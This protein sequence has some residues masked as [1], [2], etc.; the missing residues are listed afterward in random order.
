MFIVNVFL[1]ITEG[2]D[3]FCTRN[4]DMVVNWETKA[5]AFMELL[6][7]TLSEKGRF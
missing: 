2:K 3:A 1:Y 5:S 7:F 6:L 4:E